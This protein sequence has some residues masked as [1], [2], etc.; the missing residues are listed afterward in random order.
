MTMRDTLTAAIR[1]IGVR[2]LYDTPDEVEMDLALQSFQTMI[3][4]LPKVRL[5]DVLVDAAYTAKEDERIFNT[6]GSPVLITLPDTITDPITGV[7]RPPRNGAMV[8]V[9][10]TGTR[11]IY[12]SELGAWQTS[13]GLTLESEQP[14]GPEHEQGLRAM[15]AVRIAPELQRPNVPDWVVSMAEAGRRTIRQRFLQTYKITTDPLLLD[16][17]QRHGVY[18]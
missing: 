2:A 4:T 12:I 7:E 13:T 8:V 17:F 9:A 6:T 18:V 16:R 1:M 14:F 15:L 11:H 10:V 3:G 5:T